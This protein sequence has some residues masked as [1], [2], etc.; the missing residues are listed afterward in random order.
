LIDHRVDCVLEFENFS[1]D[2]YRNLLGKVAVCNGGG[3]QGDVTHL[4]G[5]VRGH[6][7]DTVGKVLPGTGDIWHVGLASQFSFRTYFAG[8]T[9]NFSRKGRKLIDHRV[10]R[11]TDPE[12]L[13]FNRGPFDLKR[14]LLVQVAFCHSRNNAGDFRSRPR[15]VFNQR[16]DR[17]DAGCPG[18]RRALQMRA[19]GH[20]AFATD[21]APNALDLFRHVGVEGDHFVKRFVDLVE[22][23]AL[24]NR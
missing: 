21:N 20:F 4:S 15:Q 8:N 18:A 12:E 22:N 10:Y 9:S 19:L 13:A 16:V 17:V 11:G 5:Q 24:C 2:V 23:T 6:R 14:H 1:F 7:V 3:Y